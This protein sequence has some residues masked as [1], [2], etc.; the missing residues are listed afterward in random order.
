MLNIKGMEN[1]IMQKAQE[2]TAING[3][4]PVIIFGRNHMKLNNNKEDNL[5]DKG[6]IPT[7]FGY[8][9]KVGNFD[10]GFVLE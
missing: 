9:C 7:I 10:D 1:S 2:F 6:Y 5:I 3:R 4:K 8:K